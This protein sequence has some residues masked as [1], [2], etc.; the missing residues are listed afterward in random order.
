LTSGAAE[1]TR[2]YRGHPIRTLLAFAAL[3][4][5]VFWC[6]PREAR[7]IQSS[8]HARASGALIAATMPW[9]VVETDGRTVTLSGTAPTPDLRLRAGQVAAAVEGVVAVRNR[10]LVGD[11][12]NQ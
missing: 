7:R 11:Q 8:I 6:A 4:G 12:A 10:M 1:P 5:A 3:V 9:A 2:K